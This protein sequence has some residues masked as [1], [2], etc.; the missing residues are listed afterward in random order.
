MTAD[1]HNRLM[2]PANWSAM[3]QKTIQLS[4]KSWHYKL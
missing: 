3:Q 1:I 4:D 2:F